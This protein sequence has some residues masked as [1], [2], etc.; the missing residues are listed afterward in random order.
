MK[1]AFLKDIFREI[2]KTKSRFFSIFAIIALG[3][4]FFAGLKVT[5][6]D[7]LV[8]QDNYFR[9]QNLM[10]IRL[11]STYGFSEKDIE[12]IEETEGIRD[13]YPS[14]SKDVFVENEENAGLIAKLMAF[15]D[16]GMNEVILLDGRLPKNPDECVVEMHDQM[17]F[18]HE[19][20]DTVSVYTTDPDDPIGDS[21]ERSEWEVVGIVMSPQYIAYDRGNSTIGDGSADTYI[22]IPEENFVLDVFTEVYITLD[23]TEGL[24]AF[25]DEYTLLA[26][27]S[28]DVFEALAAKRAPARLR[29]IKKS[30]NDE[31]A[32]AKKE[33]ADAEKKLADAEQELADAEQEISE[34]EQK[35]KDGWAEYYSGLDDYNEGIVLFE[36]GIA[37]GEKQL[38]DA[39]SEIS[40]GWRQYQKG[41]AEYEEG[42]AQFE[43]GLAQTGMSINTLYSMQDYL[44]KT[45]ESLSRLPGMDWM[46]AQLEAQLAQI[47][48][49]I[50]G[51][52]QLLDAEK[53]L[54]SAKRQLQNA[55]AEVSRGWKELEEQKISGKK[56]LEDAKKQLDDAFV[57]LRD[58]EKEL[59]EGREE[60][61]ESL[62]EFEEA[63]AEA[64]TEIADAKRKIADAEEELES[65]KDPE[66]YVFTRD[67]NPGYSSYESDVYIIESVGRVFPIFFFLVAMLVCLTTMTRMVEE[68]RTQI[69]TMKALGYGKGAIL[70]KYMVY[71]AFASVSGSVFGIALCSVVFPLIIYYAYRMRYIVPPLEMTAMP[72]MWVLVI[73]ICVFCTTLAVFMAGYA[74]LRES[75]AGLMRPKAPKA[76]KRV[77]LEKI[78]F[79]WN[80]LNFTKKV[81][82]RN[83][84]RYKKRIFMTILG[85]AGCAALTLTGFGLLSSISVVFE[86]QY[87]EI[88]NYDLIVS[89][90]SDSGEEKTD[91]VFEEL[92]DNKIS[93]K[94]LP[95]YMMSASY[96][97][98]QN[99]TLVAAEDTDSL[100]EMIIFRSSESG[101]RYELSDSGV[102]ITERFADKFGLA[103]GDEFTFYCNDMEFTAEV[104]AVAE[105]YAMH[106]IYMSG[107]YFEELSGEKFSANSV[108]S[109]MSDNGPKAQDKLANRLMS[110]DGV[111]ALTFSR[112]SMESFKS[113]VENLNY[114][115]VLIIVCAAALAFVVLYNLTNINI[116]ERIREIATIKVLGFYDNEVSAYVFR[117]NIILSVLG[118]G[119]G[120]VL[121]IW[122]HSFVMG[123]IQTDDIMFGR[124]IP[125][126]AFAAAFAMT[127]F[128]ALAVNWI[129]YFRLK[130]VSMVESLKSVE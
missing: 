50:A 8:T 14:Y 2:G 127:I 41:L 97:G 122:L 95:A 80:R 7:M 17:K 16:S 38:R 22:M 46:I 56:E 101:E 123:A 98:I 55:E 26:E 29:E 71:S 18:V 59:A 82:V 113:V 121:G 23:S 128:F 90:D 70:L 87:S 32:D 64:E 112:T 105:N 89:L 37:E 57:T 79:I 21:L 76:G 28:A 20:G 110:F 51:Y 48:A 39:E 119:A 108:F 96:N 107:E 43:A 30:A 33:I 44:E 36:K 58:S 27:E 88:F 104:D 94:N 49:A 118:A 53:E 61:E 83:L 100:G 117:E 130:K 45:I 19:I 6:P 84:F 63:K 106:F 9:D 24:S 3:A 126:W 120:L 40:A 92:D 124:V 77:L 73:A 15:P 4:G 11:V 78:P 67:D 86:K 109:V 102:I 75:P 72:L 10:D 69:G 114:I 103:P 25:S 74:E 1:S 31:L 12:A 129:M 85:I 68:Q 81:T 42:L 111:L 62:A 60:Y 34:G 115:V 54:Q 47:N 125:I 66:W 52:E 35:I 65:L 5:C 93:K 99:L 13:I 116:T 91:E